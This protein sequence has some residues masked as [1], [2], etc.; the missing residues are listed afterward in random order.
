MRDN[1]SRPR[2]TTQ[3]KASKPSRSSSRRST[4]SSSRTTSSRSGTRRASGRPTSSSR[5]SRST[6][7]RGTSTDASRSTTSRSTPRARRDSD[8]SS[9]TRSDRPVSR[10][11]SSRPGRSDNAR[12]TQRR[13]SRS[14]RTERDERSS[15]GRANSS[16]GRTSERSS[17][18]SRPRRDENARPRRD[19]S[20]RPSS[21][22]D[23]GRGRTERDN[24]GPRGSAPKRFEVKRAHSN[25]RPERKFEPPKPTLAIPQ[26]IDLTVVP[27]SVLAEIR[28]I[29]PHTQDLVK[30]Y[31]AVA[32]TAIESAEFDRAYDYAKEARNLA[33]RLA[34]VRE[35]VG[36][37]AYYAGKWAEA[38]SEFKTYMRM[39]GDP[40]FLPIMAD[41]ERGLNRPERAIALSKSR[42]VQDLD[43]AGKIEMRIVVS[44]ARRDLRQLEN[45]LAILEIPDLRS[46]RRTIEVARLRY[47]YAEVLLMMGRKI[48][49]RDWFVKA[50]LADV[51]EETDA[52]ERALKLGEI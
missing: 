28:L 19:E 24:R 51:E 8:S 10:T 29:A 32:I 16:S 27:K 33:S 14:T 6:G 12:P 7:A 42:N 43:A 22:R 23:V 49:A 3:A 20:G 36:L 50:S 18:S 25:A 46:G 37:S 26:D 21:R 45:A 9:R 17:S 34:T 4:T 11:G 47:A 30:Q 35:I 15:R 39:T 31:L 1:S 52:S 48:E 40:H 44:G 38:L 5:N 13:D 2:R 41:C